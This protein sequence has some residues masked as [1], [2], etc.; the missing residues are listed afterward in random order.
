M[1]IEGVV[2]EL[3][4]VKMHMKTDHKGIVKLR[5]PLKSCTPRDDGSKTVT[6]NASVE[7]N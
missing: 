2:F 5:L 3:C 6:I 4:I 7:I 1:L